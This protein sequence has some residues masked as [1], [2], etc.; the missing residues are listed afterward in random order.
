MK[1][2][3]DSLALNLRTLTGVRPPL[4]SLYGDGDRLEC[5]RGVWL[6]R[7]KNIFEATDL[8]PLLPDAEARALS[9]DPGVGG[10][11]GAPSA[12]L[13]DLD[14]SVRELVAAPKSSSLL[15]LFLTE[16]SSVGDGDAGED[17]FT[18]FFAF[19]GL[20]AVSC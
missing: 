4:L 16:Y 17:I 3:R 12:R 13:F 10:G 7:L 1:D 15:Q 6:C 5:L 11:V 2:L 19:A 8:P 14:V 18:R 20:P 9:A